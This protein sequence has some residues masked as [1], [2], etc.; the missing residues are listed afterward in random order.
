MAYRTSQKIQEMKDAK[1]QHIEESAAKVFAEK[2]YYQ[3]KV[4]D[5]LERADISTGSFYF[6]F[7]NKEELF[8][9]LYD[10]MIQTYLSVLQDAIDTMKDN[11]DSIAESITKA[12]SLSLQ[13]FQTKKELARIMLI[14]SVGLSAEFEKKRI[15]D[16][17]KISLVFEEIFRGLLQKEV[18]R[19]PDAKVAAVLFAGS[20]YSVITHWLQ[21]NT[22]IDLVEY[23]DPLIAYNLQALGIQCND[24]D[25][26][27][28]YIPIEIK[29]AN[30]FHKESI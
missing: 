25:L 16:H 6:Y 26:T 22:A 29:N 13:T 23:S 9:S 27:A 17:Q 4:A 12:V 20:I 21:E 15:A 11:A 3:T 10:E 1:K 2:G 8:E 7:N 19:V 24:S 30:H 14:S 28:K 18:I 5:I